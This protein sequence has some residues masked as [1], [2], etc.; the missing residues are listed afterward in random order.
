MFQTFLSCFGR[1]LLLV[2][3]QTSLRWSHRVIPIVCWVVWHD[4]W[5]NNHREN[6]GVYCIP[7]KYSLS[8]VYMALMMKGTILRVPPFPLMKHWIAEA[9]ASMRQVASSN[10]LRG[11]SQKKR[12]ILICKVSLSPAVP[13]NGKRFRCPARLRG[14]TLAKCDLIAERGLIMA[15]S[16]WYRRC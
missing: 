2:L 14:P 11:S 6:G 4:H 13:S 1:P 5:C 9:F 7:N 16:T 8:K 15:F 10:S 3:L 12:K